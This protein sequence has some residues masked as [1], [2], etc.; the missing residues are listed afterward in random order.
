LASKAIDINGEPFGSNGSFELCLS[1]MCVYLSVNVG[2]GKRAQI[3]KGHG[4]YVCMMVTAFRILLWS[5][6]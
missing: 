2:V 3:V 4:V 6:A 5:C 1:I